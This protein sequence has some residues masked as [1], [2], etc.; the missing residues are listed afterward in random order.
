MSPGRWSFESYAFS[1]TLIVD[2]KV[3]ISRIRVWSFVLGIFLLGHFKL[4][5]DR[6]YLCVVVFI[7]V[8]KVVQFTFR[9]KS[10]SFVRINLVQEKQNLTGVKALRLNKA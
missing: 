8:I 6:V 7:F 1:L 3:F 4:S 2:W 9:A 5:E 10:I